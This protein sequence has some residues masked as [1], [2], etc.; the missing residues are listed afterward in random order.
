MK[1]VTGLA[2]VCVI[3]GGLVVYSTHAL[4][5]DDSTKSTKI[6]I[7]TYDNRAVAIAFV[8]S[9]FNPVAEK[10]AAY[11]K[12]KAAG[13]Q[14]KMKE[15][16]TWGTR[17]QRQLHFQG[18]GRAPVDDLLEP[19]R[20]PLAKLARDKQLAAISM[21]CDFTSDQ[22]EVVDVTE[23]IVRLYDPSEKTLQTVRAVRK[24]KPTRLVELTDHP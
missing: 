15:L 8:P 7:G 16:E 18:F 22:V 5:A 10:R 6:R 2:L 19:V 21:H 20:E 23:D 3:A 11:E 14:A 4:A 24:V 13:D 17:Y 1:Q 9:R 12:A